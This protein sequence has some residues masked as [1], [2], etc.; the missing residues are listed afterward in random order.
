MEMGED[1]GCV[2]CRCRR[3]WYDGVE[4]GVH[5]RHMS[6]TYERAGLAQYPKDEGAL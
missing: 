6:P 3:G 2:R 1:G 5:L 4:D